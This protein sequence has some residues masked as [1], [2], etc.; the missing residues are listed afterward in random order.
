MFRRYL[1]P[2]AALTALALAGH[3]LAAPLQPVGTTFKSLRESCSRNESTTYQSRFEREAVYTGAAL[4]D[5]VN[6][7]VNATSS[8]ALPRL[9]LHVVSSETRRNN[10]QNTVISRRAWESSCTASPDCY[11]QNAPQSGDW[12]QITVTMN[13]G[14]T[15]TRYYG[16]F[17]NGVVTSTLG[18]PV[19]VAMRDTY[20]LTLEQPMGLDSLTLGL[21]PAFYNQ[22]SE[23]RVRVSM[24]VDLT[25]ECNPPPHG[26]QSGESI[27][28]FDFNSLPALICND[29]P[30]NPC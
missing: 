25:A 15:D 16:N 4:T 11:S 1:G 17:S 20:D 29:A 24:G 28:L 14:A 21:N 2:L 22:I 3:A 13:N 30:G 19:G 27:A 9:N 23:I 10:S 26:I 8:S 12:V 7:A 18:V 5:L 6:A